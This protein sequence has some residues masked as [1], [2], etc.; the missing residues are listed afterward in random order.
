MIRRLYKDPSD[1]L[2]INISRKVNIDIIGKVRDELNNML[3]DYF[4]S[5]CMA[6][7]FTQKAKRRS[8]NVN[9]VSKE[10]YGWD[11]IMKLKDLYL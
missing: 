6:T 7:Y 9:A 10:K 11:Y 1:I 5:Y 3:I 8:I 2:K 4:N